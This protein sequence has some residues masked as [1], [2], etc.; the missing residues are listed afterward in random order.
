MLK[1]SS[2]FIFIFYSFA[3]FAAEQEQSNQVHYCGRRL[4]NIFKAPLT[5]DERE[6]LVRDHFS[7]NPVCY[8][9]SKDKQLHEAHSAA[10]NA[11]DSV[12]ALDIGAVIAERNNHWNYAKYS[13]FAAPLGVV[14]GALGVLC[15]NYVTRNDKKK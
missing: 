4:Y 2:I 8:D 13:W 6:K 3:F 12:V 14:T 7:K 10:V 5:H 15:V 9:Q 11:G 1:T